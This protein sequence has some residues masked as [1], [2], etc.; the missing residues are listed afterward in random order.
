MANTNAPTGFT[1]VMNLDGSSWN[2]KTRMYFVPATDSD[3]MYI[4]DLVDLAGS[5]NTTIQNGFKIGTLPTVKLITAGATNRILGSI[6]D[7]Y[8]PTDIDDALRKRYRVASTAT[9][10][11]VALA[12][13]TIFSA[14]NDGTSVATSAG[15]NCN[16][17]LGS[18]GSASSGYSSH[19]I[20][21]SEIGN[22]ATYQL[23]IDRLR[24]VENNAI[25]QYAVD[26]VT[27]N[28]PRLS[29]DTVGV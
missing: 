10:V 17:T 26:L 12:N 29:P 16:V 27:I 13:N 1:P 2:G 6:V 15:T 21:T 5:S 28:L 7:I 8:K 19:Q 4:G 24:N 22:D 23:S 14:Q 18:G 3:A 11:L 9:I 25:G 20:D